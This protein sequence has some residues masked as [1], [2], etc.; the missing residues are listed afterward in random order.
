MARSRTHGFSYACTAR[1]GLSANFGLAKSFATRN[2]SLASKFGK[3]NIIL[4]PRLAFREICIVPNFVR[5]LWGQI[6]GHL[7]NGTRLQFLG[8][9]RAHIIKVIKE[10]APEGQN[11]NY[12][13]KSV[14]FFVVKFLVNFYVY[15]R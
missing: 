4:L 7:S 9:F 10:H 14:S 11:I 6:L 8:R 2:F 1:I 5:A 12:T 3:G 15:Y 13:N